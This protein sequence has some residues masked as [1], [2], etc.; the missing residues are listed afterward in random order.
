MFEKM[1]FDELTDRMLSN[2]S[3]KFDKREGSVIYDAIAP[4][5]LE[6][7]EFYVALDMLVDEVYADSASYYYLIKRAAE[8]GITPKEETCAVGRM[9][10]TPVE[11]PISLGDRFNLGDLNYIVTSI[12][13]VDAGSYHIE[14]E[15]AGTIGNQ[16]LGD[17]LPL[18]T[19]NELNNM[20]SA[21]LTEIIVPGKE[22]EDVESFRERYFASFN[23]ESFGG[24]KTDYIEKVNNIAGVGGCKP[25]RAWK[26]DHNPSKMIPNETVQKWFGQQS[27]EILGYEVYTWLNEVFGA[28]NEKLLTVGGTVK[29]I[30]ISSEYGTPSQSLVQMVQEELDPMDTTGE[31]DGIAPIGHVV[32][33][34]GVEETSINIST[35]IE[36]SE[37]FSFSN[38]QESIE[39]AIDSYF[40][41]LRESWASNNNLIIRISQIESRLLGLDG[42]VDVKDTMLNGVNEN[43]VLD[44]NCIPV[45]G[46]VIG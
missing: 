28:A 45:R 44:V 9:E 4:A 11:T 35:S 3:D 10:V 25:I 32:N 24:N 7:A 41:E 40:L 29:V 37:G 23:N 21:T 30:I 38:M 36:Y 13:D 6:L 2:V 16:Q 1:D 19:E 27:E 8:R 39:S 26:G 22:E 17:L 18:E 15:T 31:G 14:C 43:I 42:I 20:E 12:I 46:D 34:V 5:A 33:V